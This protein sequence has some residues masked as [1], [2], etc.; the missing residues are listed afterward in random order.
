MEKFNL[1]NK[2]DQYMH[3]I[4]ITVSVLLFIGFTSVVLG[5]LKA[6]DYANYV[7]IGV[8]TFFVLSMSGWLI[9]WLIYEIRKE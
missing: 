6:H 7:I 8:G 1:S 2:F 3:C 4:F 9:T 5:L